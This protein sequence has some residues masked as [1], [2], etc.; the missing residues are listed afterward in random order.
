MLWDSPQLQATIL[1]NIYIA[2]NI[3]QVFF[4]LIVKWKQYKDKVFIV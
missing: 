4:K 1:Y 2:Y 3:L